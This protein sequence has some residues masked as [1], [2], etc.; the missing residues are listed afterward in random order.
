MAVEENKLNL[1]QGPAKLY[2]VD[3]GT[4]N[5]PTTANFSSTPSG[6][7]CLGFTNGGVSLNLSQEWTALEVDQLTMAPRRVKTAEEASVSTTMAELGIDSIR[8]A[9]NGG[10]KTSGSGWARFEPLDHRAGGGI[11]TP[12]KM[13]ILKGLSPA[14]TDGVNLVRFVVLRNVLSTSGVTFDYSK[15]DQS[16]AEV[17]F[18]AD[19][20][21][22]N[23]RAWFVLDEV[24]A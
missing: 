17:T 14:S 12:Y 15:G 18:E 21:D 13:V 4:E 19:Y 6:W 9:L 22:E 20:V 2:I 11:E 16:G 1:I 24:P 10:D 7:N 3:I 23:T 5:E 8:V